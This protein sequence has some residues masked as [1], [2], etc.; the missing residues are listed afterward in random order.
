MLCVELPQ[1]EYKKIWLLQLELVSARIKGVINDD[2]LLLLEH[3]PVFTIGK[4]GDMG[5]LKVSEEFLRQSRIPFIPVE[6]GGDITY[7]GPG[8]LVGYPIINLRLLR[9]GLRKYV[10]NLE[11]LMIRAASD[12][13]VKATKYFKN[14]GAWVKNCKLGSI[15]IYAKRNVVF[16]GFAF[17]V[18]VSL[19]PFGWINP[20][21]L[22][23]A[24]VT[25]LLNELSTNVS[26]VSSR[27][28]IKHHLARVL[29]TKLEP[30]SFKEL[31]KSLKKQ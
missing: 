10:E 8:Q 11:D 24:G 30:L 19:A 23:K 25:S 17:N 7:H 4:W 28:S 6:R 29:K 20:C 16:H 21:G 14:R 3:K 13:G 2:V 9:I 5:N 12:F 22:K 1:S 31:K 18:N 26:M 15:G 27:E